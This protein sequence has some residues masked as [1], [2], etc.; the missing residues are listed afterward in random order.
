MYSGKDSLRYGGN[1]PKKKWSETMENH[2][3]SGLR[4]GVFERFY[5]GDTPDTPT[6]F[7]LNKHLLEAGK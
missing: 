4:Q 1:I 7:L 2:T 6:C 5:L 3:F